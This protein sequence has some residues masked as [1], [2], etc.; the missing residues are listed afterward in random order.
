MCE[1]LRGLLL[2]VEVINATAVDTA[3]RPTQRTLHHLKMLGYAFPLGEA[4]EGAGRLQAYCKSKNPDGLSRE[5][6]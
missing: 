4:G 1:R 5:L 3:A 2:S 6:R